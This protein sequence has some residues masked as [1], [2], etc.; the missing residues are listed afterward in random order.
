MPP[1]VCLA[2]ALEYVQR[3]WSAL[4]VCPSDHQGVSGAHEQQCRRP[5]KEPLC[6]W[7]AY[8][9]RLP[10]A[11]E[12]R[13]WWARHPGA[14]VGLALGTVSGLVGIDVDGSAG[15]QELAA[16]AQDDLPDTLE[17]LTRGGGRRLLY[18]LPSGVRRGGSDPSQ[19]IS[20]ENVR[21]LADGSHTV[22]PPS[23]GYSWVA[24]HGLDQIAP[25]PC[26]S[27]LRRC[28]GLEEDERT[29][30]IP[31]E[32]EASAK[33]W[34]PLSPTLRVRPVVCTAADLMAQQFSELRWAVPGLIP[35]GGT[36][37][38]GRPKTGKSWLTLGLALAIAGGGTA[39]GG[40]AVASGE[41]LY[42]A[43]EDGP[44][45]LR[46]R[47]EKLLTAL[48]QTA[49]A[50]LHLATAWPRSGEGGLQR[51]DEWLHAHSGARLVIVD[52]L[53]RIRDRRDG[54]NVY[55]EDYQTLAR[56][57]DLGDRYACAVVVVH[58]TRKGA[59]EDPLDC[60]SGTLGLTGAA[61]CALVL[62]HQRHSEEARLF[63]TGRDVDER[64]MLLL[65]D[66]KRCLWSQ[67]EVR[68][69]LTREQRGVLEAMQQL[70]SPVTP[71]ELVPLIHKNKD[72]LKQLLRRMADDYGLIRHGQRRGTYELLAESTAQRP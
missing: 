41:V 35:E 17:F 67:D 38:A 52:T 16:L 54:G 57:K 8:Q 25:A 49:P 61:D 13:L 65:W 15:E 26:P 60:I 20:S 62:R 29:E 6:D 39:L 44:R 69:G 34:H 7:R 30:L 66:P 18:Q 22:M 31:S 50:A 68:D 70:K 51:I 72:A 14:G 71:A 28:L 37:L 19:H 55:E 53:A 3:G 32:P 33:S 40:L 4:P 9:Q 59:S 63:V 12:L 64:E 27:W 45:R 36:I 24:G 5:G 21:L 2:A 46:R 48:G 42:L 56:L 23:P 10:R 58:H 11:G 47:L 43:L 1:S